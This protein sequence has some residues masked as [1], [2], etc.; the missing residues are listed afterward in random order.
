MY[1]KSFWTWQYKF[2]FHTSIHVH[3][4]CTG[5]WYFYMYM[6]KIMIKIC[7]KIYFNN[8]STNIVKNI[9]IKQLII[10][11]GTQLINHYHHLLNYNYV[12]L[13]SEVL[14]GK[15]WVILWRKIS[16]PVYFSDTLWVAFLSLWFHWMILLR[17][18]FFLCLKMLGKVYW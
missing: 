3:K 1:I 10:K 14:C 8:I 17:N 13:I 2:I 16:T 15:I 6:N 11:T 7:V 12:V 4:K 9:Y 5:Y 18:F